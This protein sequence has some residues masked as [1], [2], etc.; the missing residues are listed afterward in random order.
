MSSPYRKL[1]AE[2]KALGIAAN[3]SAD[4]LRA[5]I[6]AAKAPKPVAPSADAQIEIGP[7][8]LRANEQL[9]ITVSGLEPQKQA[10]LRVEP[11]VSA[12][13]VKVDP[14]GQVQVVLVPRA[15]SHRLTIEMMGRTIQRDFDVA[16]Q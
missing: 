11:E 14:F 15:G 10:R 2:A 12:R 5:A 7:R 16:E 1:Q 13:M 9:T 3:Q 4:D 6:A 8:P